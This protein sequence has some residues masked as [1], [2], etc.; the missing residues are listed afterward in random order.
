[1]LKAYATFAALTL[2]F[3]AI[4]APPAATPIESTSDL[5]HEQ[6]VSATGFM[7]CQKA[8]VVNVIAIILTYPSG[9][10]VR[11]DMHHMHGFTDAGELVKY[12][13][14]AGD[15]VIYKIDCHGGLDT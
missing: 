9:K 6:P 5:P 4:A 15:Q 2:A 13:T 7:Q 14:A 11:V 1:M 3:S 8:G 12:A 10:V